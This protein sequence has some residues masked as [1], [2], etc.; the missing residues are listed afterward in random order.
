MKN[1]YEYSNFSLKILYC[2]SIIIVF[3]YIYLK[4]K[5][6]K[7]IISF[8]NIGLYTGFISLFFTSLYQY[9]DLAWK[10]L[11]YQNANIFFKY[12]NKNLSINLIGIVVFYLSLIIFEMREK[13]IKLSKLEFFFEKNINLQII[14]WVNLIVICMWLILIYSQLGF[15]LPIFKD[16]TFLVNSSFQSF[17]N[18]FNSILSYSLIVYLFCKKRPLVLSFINLILLFGTGNRGGILGFFLLCYIYYLYTTKKSGKKKYLLGIF[19]CFGLLFLLFFLDKVRGAGKFPISYRILYGNT[20]S[21]IRDGAFILYGIEKIKIG[22]LYGKMYIADFLSFIP[23]EFIKYREIYGYSNFTTKTLFGWYGHY[24][25][26]G[27]S[28]MAPYINFG[29]AGVILMGIYAAYGYSKLEN[30]YYK[31]KITFK[32]ILFLNLKASFIV[33][34]LLPSGFMYFYVLCCYIIL[35]IGLKIIIRSILKE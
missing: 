22:L 18:I 16:R 29:I 14:K 9:N 20:F 30:Y 1:F 3:I 35:I 2:L 7:Y 33:S 11:G 19:V 34:F 17:Y 24:G 10:A 32:N 23:S 15:S 28:Y 25:L 6:K 4:H 8:F 26:R 5:N 21:D 13:K 12:I 27:G 31:K